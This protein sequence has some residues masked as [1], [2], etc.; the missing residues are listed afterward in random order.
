MSNE[1]ALV[2]IEEKRV[3]FYGDEIIAVLAETEGQQQIYVPVRQ[4]CHYLGVGWPSQ[5]QRMKRDSVLSEDMTSVVIM[6]T[7]VPEQQYKQRYTVICLPLEDVPGWLFG[8]SP[9]RVRPELQEKIKRYRR[10]CY[11]VLWQ[12]FQ[13]DTTALAPYPDNLQSTALAAQYNHLL[14]IVNL[15]REHLEIVSEATTPLPEKLDRVIYLL[16]SLLGRQEITETKVARIDERTK[17]LTPEHARDVAELVNYM[18]Y[19]TKQAPT[20]LDHYRIYGTLKRR[21]RAASYK[22]IADE[23]FSEVMDF[24]RDLLNQ[25]ITGKLPQQGSLFL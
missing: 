3:N 5:Y 24:L 14:G 11:R 17:H 13:A 12:A 4:L 6:T 19:Q 25:A 2:P 15:M 20:P 10:E 22:E 7:L 16:E 8:I 23:R 21:F 9:K 18:V 1:T